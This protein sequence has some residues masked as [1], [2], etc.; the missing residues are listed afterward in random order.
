MTGL[1]DERDA[2]LS[3]RPTGWSITEESTGPVKPQSLGRGTKSDAREHQHQGEQTR[4]RADRVQMSPAP[5]EVTRMRARRIEGVVCE[6]AVRR[7]DDDEREGYDRTEQ[8]PR[9]EPRG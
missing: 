1:D 2:R 3:P 4:S 7:G 8:Q 6:R 9:E 5:E